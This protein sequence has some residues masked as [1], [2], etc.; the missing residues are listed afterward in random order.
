MRHI[1]ATSQAS[2]RSLHTIAASEAEGLIQDQ[3]SQAHEA[4]EEGHAGIL[5]TALNMF[6]NIMGGAVLVL[7]S[8]M[9]DASIGFGAPLLL[10]LGLMSVTTMLMLVHSAERTQKYTYRTMLCASVHE[11]VGRGFEIGLFAYTFGVL[12]EYGRII[13]DSMPA[14]AADFFHITSGFLSHGWAWL[15]MACVPFFIFGS[16]PQLSELKW[17]SFVGFATIV[18]VEVL[19]V[20]LFATG[21]YKQNPPKAVA[22][23]VDFFCASLDVFRT[24]PV[25][26]VAYSCHYNVPVYYRELEKRTL[27]QFYRVLLTVSPV[28]I[29]VY[30][31]V[32]VTGYL[33][34]GNTVLDTTRGNIV[35]AY[36]H[37]DTAV[38]IG[39]L[40]LFFH[41][42][43]AFPIVAVACRSC[44]NSIV[45]G[46]PKKTHLIHIVEAFALVSLSAVCA[47]FV[48]GIAF[49]VDMIGSLFGVSIVY[50]IPSVIYIGTFRKERFELPDVTADVTACGEKDA[51]TPSVPAVPRHP[52]LYVLAY[53]YVPL[54]IA[55]SIIALSV[56]IQRF[57]KGKS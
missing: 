16:F 47:H 28:I 44:L 40:G 2:A 6:C 31:S 4:A 39:R 57:T 26:A 48:P 51:V 3:P 27:P 46:T 55:G 49:V 30:M 50:I 5:G 25:L 14:V 22:D 7:P 56:T 29:T 1:D 10:S 34:F 13:S 20:T 23:D 37:T 38:N 33:T 19:I 45:F 17:S 52:V 41:F 9:R 18:Y 15:L 21:S 12:V 43:T 11:Y 54:G 8:A 32:A 35:N 24:I 42:C 36:R 53:C